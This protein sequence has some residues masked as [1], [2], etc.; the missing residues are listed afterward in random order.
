MQNLRDDELLSTQV[1]A[2]LEKGYDRSEIE[3]GLV[4]EGHDVV[5][6]REMLK[7]LDKQKNTKRKNQA[8]S[9]L[10]AGAAACILSLVCSVTQ[11]YPHHLFPIFLYGLGSFGALLIVA[12]VL[13][14]LF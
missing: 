3:K 14:I 6:V 12:G 2:L 9:L 5:S 7:E 10:V 1:L 11:F 8:Y 4:D 13:M